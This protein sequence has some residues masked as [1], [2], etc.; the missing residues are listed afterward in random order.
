LNDMQDRQAR[1]VFLRQRK[2]IWSGR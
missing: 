2:R 1:L